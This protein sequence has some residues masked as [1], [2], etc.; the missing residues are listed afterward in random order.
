M[1][2]LTLEHNKTSRQIRFFKSFFHRRSKDI[3]FRATSNFCTKNN[4][5]TCIRFSNACLLSKLGAMR[6]VQNIT[7][8]VSSETSAYVATKQHCVGRNQE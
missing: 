6:R 3:C 8:F 4:F 7:R 5:K 1:K 2:W